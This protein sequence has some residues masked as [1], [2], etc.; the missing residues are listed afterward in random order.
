MV[1]AQMLT[2]HAKQMRVL[3]EVKLRIFED[4]LVLAL[5]TIEPA[6]SAAAGEDGVRAIVRQALDEGGEAGIETEQ[7]IAALALLLLR[8]PAETAQE[9]A[10]AWGRKTWRNLAMPP[11]LRIELLTQRVTRPTA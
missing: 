10:G 11:D 7:D 3:A 6:R 9:I 8:H 4:R 2:I 5:Q 1:P